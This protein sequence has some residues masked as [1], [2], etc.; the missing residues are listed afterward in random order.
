M[1]LALTM[2]RHPTVVEMGI[3]G[4][5][6]IDTIVNGGSSVNVLPENVWKKLGKPM[7]WPPTF[8]LRMTDQHEIKPLGTLMV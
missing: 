7:L 2:G 4:T 3:L 1:L 8:Q 5:F 6:L